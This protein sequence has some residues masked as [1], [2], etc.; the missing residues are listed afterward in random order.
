[1]LTILG[2]V[3]PYMAFIPWIGENGFN[4]T[5]LLSEAR[6]NRISEFAWLDV[7]ISAVVSIGFIIY[8]GK[9]I[10]VKHMWLPI[11]GTLTVGVSFGLP[12][13]LLLREIH[14]DKMKNR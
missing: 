8:E 1:M 9:R 2:I 14:M 10:G 6:Q 12:L 4:L 5:M 11:I 13:F 3:L 7:L